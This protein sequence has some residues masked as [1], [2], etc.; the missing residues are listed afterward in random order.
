VLDVA[1]KVA[2]VSLLI[3]AVARPDLPQFAG[4][5][6]T[7]RAIAYPLAKVPAG[8]RRWIALNPLAGIVEGFRSAI[9]YGRAP[10]WGLLALSASLTLASCVGAFILFKRLDKYFADV[11]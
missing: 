1:V 6:M 5:A 9:V 11:I 10:D 3:L 8:W 7:G 4:K 2:V